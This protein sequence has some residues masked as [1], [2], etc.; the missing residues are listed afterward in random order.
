[1]IKRLCRFTLLSIFF[2]LSACSNVAI[3]PPN[4]PN[5]LDPHGPDAAHIAQLWWVMLG[6]GT[7]I[8]LIVIGLLFAAL[9]RGKRATA[10][11]TPEIENLD[12]GRRWPILGGILILQRKVEGKERYVLR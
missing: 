7:V 2:L 9:L 1:M 5:T 10:E 12:E 4:S 3:S 11:T 8:F 6:L